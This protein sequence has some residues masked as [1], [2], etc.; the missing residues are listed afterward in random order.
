MLHFDTV[1]GNFELSNMSQRYQIARDRIVRPGGSFIDAFR[2]AIVEFTSLGERRFDIAGYPHDSEQE[3]LIRDWAEVGKDI[4][5]AEAKIRIL[6]LT[7]C[8]CDGEN[9]TTQQGHSV[10]NGDRKKFG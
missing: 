2:M 9:E 10:Q 6:A 1:H 4:K 8:P 3:A 7:E 5:V